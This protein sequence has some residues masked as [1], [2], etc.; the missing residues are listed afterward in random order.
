MRGFFCTITGDIKGFQSDNP[1][2]RKPCGQASTYN[3]RG[4]NLCCLFGGISFLYYKLLG[5]LLSKWMR[6]FSSGH[7][8]D[9]TQSLLENAALSDDH[10]FRSMMHGLPKKPPNHMEILK[11]ESFLPTPYLYAVRTWASDGQYFELNLRYRFLQ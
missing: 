3:F 9:A 8:C 4:K 1:K 7:G 5:S 6:L 11:I 10:L 2:M